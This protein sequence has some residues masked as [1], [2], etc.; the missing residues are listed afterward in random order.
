MSTERKKQKNPPRIQFAAYGNATAREL[1]G[2]VLRVLEENRG[3]LPNKR[4][5][6]APGTRAVAKRYFSFRRRDQSRED[7][8]SKKKK[9]IYENNRNGVHTRHYGGGSLLRAGSKEGRSKLKLYNF[10]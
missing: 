9:N 4:S 7:H 2:R 10:S 3:R 8:N 6:K 5:S 1:H